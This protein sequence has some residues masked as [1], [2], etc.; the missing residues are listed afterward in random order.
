M[1]ALTTRIRPSRPLLETMQLA[2]NILISLLALDQ[3]AAQGGKCYKANSPPST[4][5]SPPSPPPPTAV[6]NPCL[7]FHNKA[8]ESKGLAKF[9]WSSSLA[10]A[11]S[12]F[13]IQLDRANT[14]NHSEAPSQGE[15]IYYGTGSCQ[16][17][18]NMWMAEG[19]YYNGQRLNSINLPAIGHFTQVMSQSSQQVGC[20]QS[21][22]VVVCKYFPPGNIQG[23]MLQHY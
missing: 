11:S 7:D 17:A 12:Q 15:N 14:I 18:V 9:S 13:A 10:S 21:G 5:P 20:G 19:K 6:Y 3:V 2:F 8:R 23:M 16:D 1:G 4:P 22:P